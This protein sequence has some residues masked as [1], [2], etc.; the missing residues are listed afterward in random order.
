[1]L[2]RF[3]GILCAFVMLIP[4]VSGLT[5]CGN[6]DD[7]DIYGEMD[8][9]D[10][11]K[12]ELSS[13]EFENTKLKQEEDLFGNIS[14]SMPPYESYYTGEEISIN[15]RLNVILDDANPYYYLLVDWGDGTWGYVGP[16][17]SS[18]SKKSTCE[19][20][21]VYKKAGTYEVKAAGISLN[22]GVLY[23]WTPSESITVTGNDYEYEGMIDHLRPIASSYQ[24]G[25]EPEN[26][27]DGTADYF[28]S[29]PAADYNVSEWVGYY[30]D[31]AYQLD[32]LEVKIPNNAETFPANLAIEYTTDYGKTWYSL[33]KYY[34]L[35]DYS[36]GRFQPIMGFPNPS[37]A[38][39]SLALDGI[40]AN[41]IRIASKVFL[42]SA[43]TLAVEEMRVYGNPDL[44]LYTSN[45][46]VFD[47]D[48]NNMWTI[49]GT[50]K[51]EPIVSGSIKGEATNQSP[52]R[53]G[54][55]M[56]GS[57]EWLEWNGL[58]FNWTTYDYVKDAYLETLIDT[59]YGSDGW[60]DHPGY[61]W[62]T[63]TAPKHLD[64]QNHY[65]YN[66]TYIMAVR[67][68]LLQGN[69]TKIIQN[70][71]EYDFMDVP[72]RYG[73]TIKDKLEKAMDYQLTV[74]EGTTGVLT[75][76]DPNNDGT[77]NGVASNYW[78]V[79]KSCGYKSA[80]ENALFYGSLLA[81]ADIK[82]YM[83]E[84]EEAQYYRDLAA[85]TKT[86]FNKLFWD[87][88][89]ERFITSVNVE[90]F[91]ADYGMT[92]VNFYAIAYGVADE[93]KAIKVYEWLDGKR[94]IEGDTSQGED[95][96]GQFIYAPRTNTLDVYEV[97]ENLWW[98]HGGNLPCAP[99]TFGGYGHT[100]QNGGTI[101]YISHYDIMG[102][103]VSTDVESAYGRFRTIMEEFHKDSLRRN[104]YMMYVQNGT[105]G[106]GE[107]VEGVIG[108]FPESGLVPLTFI[109]GFLG[110][111]AMPEGLLIDANLPDELE[112]AGVREYL[113]GNRVYTIEVSKQI[114]TAEV[115]QLENGNYLVRVPAS[116]AY[117][118]TLDNRLIRQESAE[119]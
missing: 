33:P 59:R 91:R 58:K 7:K 54:F 99:G 17:V 104:Q 90:G 41:G 83:G 35:Y 112:Y 110:I 88:V 69:N 23:G 77:E 118:I 60:S 53:T 29:Q 108:E 27:T 111:K 106:I 13:I 117:V 65:T 75:I 102:R 26:I 95:I 25:H 68:Y 105:Q 28:I 45:N 101:F 107:Y 86:E 97:N 85:K 24:E 9:Q 103:L 55:A 5:A 31:K 81:M 84:T 48:L 62:A 39:L 96:Y 40:A 47:G 16:Y 78:D 119:N 4:L 44:Q 1:M 42:T 93:E 61:I 32:R 94:I 71:I 19:I 18:S 74:L 109:T 51:T 80:Y 87:P 113:Y 22:G 14:L 89:K 11:K 49:F 82:E 46:D 2:K 100:M 114:R 79:F 36:V 92:F 66:S 15:A 43:R 63:P 10:T 56:I 34:Y 30:F 6:R 115:E 38:T 98:N 116:E 70:G 73:Q 12:Y 21:H 8:V 72:N 67:N 3:I 52:F 20:T 37:G 64:E 50:A 76:N 57:T